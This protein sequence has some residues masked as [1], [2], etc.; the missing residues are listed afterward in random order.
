M[1]ANIV[2][3]AGDDKLIITIED[4]PNYDGDSLEITLANVTDLS[5]NV[6]DTICWKFIVQTHPLYWNPK[7]ISI[8]VY[9]G[10]KT[11]IQATLF[12]ITTDFQSA[13]LDTL[14]EKGSTWLSFL[15]NVS[16]SGGAG[17]VAIGIEGIDIG[18]YSDTLSLIV[19]GQPRNPE[20]IINLKVVAEAPNWVVNHN[21]FFHQMVVTSN[22]D[23]STNVDATS[24]DSLDMISVWLN[25]TIRGVANINRQ[26][27]YHAA[28]LTISGHDGEA[29]EELEFRVWDASK[30]IEY[31]AFP[32]ET[33]V[34]EK[35]ERIGSFALPEILTIDSL[36]HRAR[37]IP[38]NKN[39]T[40][41]SLNTTLENDSTKNWLKTLTQTTTGDLIY[42]GKR[43]AQYNEGIGWVAEGNDSLPTL[44]A[45]EGY[46]IYLENG[47]D[48]IEDCSGEGLDN[49]FTKRRPTPKS[50]KPS[51]FVKNKSVKIY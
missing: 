22:Y 38:L 48:T 43:F 26:G 36:K 39:W 23:F 31:D 35:N 20:L 50:S 49:R 2:C 30:G 11:T 19:N 33:I 9:K 17:T 21:D 5:G 1:A 12:N 15:E 41:F 6:A 8:E 45:N 3:S 16:F 24:I 4:M 28:S 44:N 40:W 10:T 14:S 47:P 51:R 25:N 46:L 13:T 42:N 29:N 27:E 32:K 37:Y 7:E 18:T 34:F